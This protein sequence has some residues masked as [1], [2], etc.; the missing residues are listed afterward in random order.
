MMEKRLHVVGM[1]GTLRENSTSRWA[2]VRALQ[3]A[4]QSGATTE[5]LDLRELNLPLFDPEKSL[6]EYGPNVAHLIDSVR[7][8]NAMIWSTGAY[9]GTVAGVTKN[10]LDF[11]ELL[12]DDERPYL[13]AKVIGLIAT[14]GGNQAAV[15]AVNAM[16]H[17]VHALRGIVAPLLVVIPQSWRVFS[18]DGKLTDETWGKRLDQIGRLV[19]ETTARFSKPNLNIL[20][21]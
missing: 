20:N 17:V 15:N 11:F 21:E 1:G 3:A 8:A 13:D 12:A 6:E 2:L 14:A 4:S 19:V 10:A 9:H 16:V 7:R 18:R 5:L